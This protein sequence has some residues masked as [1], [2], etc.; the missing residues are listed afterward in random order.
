MIFFSFLL[1][2]KSD[3]NFFFKKFLFSFDLMLTPIFLGPE[4]EIQTLKWRGYLGGLFFNN[5]CKQPILAISSGL[6]QIFFQPFSEIS[7]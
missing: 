6:K 3:N 7:D 5:V 2:Y 1:F 4:F